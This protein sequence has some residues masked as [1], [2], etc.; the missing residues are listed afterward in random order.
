MQTHLEQ[1][2]AGIVEAAHD[3]DARA[4]RRLLARFAE[5]ATISDL[6]ALQHALSRPEPAVRARSEVSS[7]F[8]AI[9]LRSIHALRTA[10]SLNS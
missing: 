9:D 4:L 1:V 5:Q 10:W 8:R 6:C 7:G 2:I 3:G